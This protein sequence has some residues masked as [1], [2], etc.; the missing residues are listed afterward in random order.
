MATLAARSLGCRHAGGI[1]MSHRLPSINSM[2][3]YDLLC[4]SGGTYV[5]QLKGIEEHRRTYPQGHRN[6]GDGYVLQG[7]QRTPMTAMRALGINARRDRKP[8]C[9][10]STGFPQDSHRIS[11]GPAP[12]RDPGQKKGLNYHTGLLIRSFPPRKRDSSAPAYGFLT[13]W[14]AGQDPR[15]WAGQAPD[16]S[17]ALPAQRARNAGTSPRNRLSPPVG[18]GRA[19]AGHG[20]S[21]QGQ[22]GIAPRRPARREKTGAG[23]IQRALAPIEPGG[24]P[25]RPESLESNSLEGRKTP[26]GRRPWRSGLGKTLGIRAGF[27]GEKIEVKHG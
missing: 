26:R 25:R 19:S 14:A 10:F 16:T 12:G 11:T 3:F 22:A 21:H 13:G 2:F 24:S 1:P 7:R 27:S 4:S 15:P 18:P 9:H 5:L 17:G 6:L 23:R 20:H 8:L